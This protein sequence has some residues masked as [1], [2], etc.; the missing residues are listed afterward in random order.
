MLKHITTLLLSMLSIGVFSQYIDQSK[1]TTEF[2]IA[3]ATQLQSYPEAENVIYI[4]VDGM[5]YNSADRARAVLAWRMAS[6]DFRPFNVNITTSSSVYNSTAIA[7][8]MTV[9]LN[10]GFNSGLCSLAGFG[11]GSIQCIATVDN[12]SHEIGHGLGLSHD[13]GSINSVGQYY[14]GNDYWGSIMGYVDLEMMGTF[15]QGEYEGA[16][17]LEDDLQII[18]SMIDY[19]PDDHSNT[20]TNAT[21][22]VITASDSI[23]P[24]NNNGIIE[25]SDDKDVFA[26][27]FT[28]NSDVVLWITPLKHYNNLHVKARILDEQGNVISSSTALQHQGSLSTIMQ[29]AKIEGSFTAGIYYLEISNSGYSENNISIYDAYGSLG[30]YEISGYAGVLTPRAAIGMKTTACLSEEVELINNSTGTEASYQWTIEGANLSESS[31]KSPTVQFTSKGLHKVTLELTNTI[32]TDKTERWIEVGSNTFEFVVTKEELKKDFHVSL[33]NTTINQKVWNIEYDDLQEKDTEHLSAQT[34]LNGDCYD[35]T[36][37]D[38]FDYADCGLYP[39]SSRPYQEGSEVSYFGKRYKATQWT[40]KEPGNGES[41]WSFMGNCVS[42]NE[43]AY[44]T[45]SLDGTNE[46]EFIKTSHIDFN[47]A[48]SFTQNNLCL[49][50]PK[51]NIVVITSSP[52]NC[53]NVQFKADDALAA[54]SIVWDFGEYATPQSITGKGP[55]DIKFSTSGLQ[56]IELSVNGDT[57]LKEIFITNILTTPSILI[58]ASSDSICLGDEVTFIKTTLNSGTIDW[59][60]NEVFISSGESFVTNNLKNKDTIEAVLT[61]SDE[62]LTTPT[63]TSNFI[64]ILVDNCVSGLSNDLENKIEV[65]PNP[66]KDILFIKGKNIQNIQIASASGQIILETTQLQFDL[67]ALS[68]GIYFITVKN[69][70]G[71]I[72]QK[73]IKE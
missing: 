4:N 59:Y 14:Q 5:V 35:L 20:S 38:I 48:D 3:E 7:N 43:N 73:I 67:S 37:V 1:P 9:T 31:E 50:L 64:T 65:F 26:L 40:N 27:T 28:E 45:I 63:V 23:N 32:G 60:V 18:S 47:G 51:D 17:N 16:S 12:L 54:S 29:A 2:S 61:I 25:K 22:L 11:T 10:A 36:V 58:E 34:C 13:G 66:T 46:H 72:V 68:S 6:E 21:D 62:C 15:S 8:R 42:E 44:Y 52:N 69:E 30:Y 55:H 19:R 57:E 53:H 33:I 49:T 56:T 41:T 39:W 71:L 70:K 24:L